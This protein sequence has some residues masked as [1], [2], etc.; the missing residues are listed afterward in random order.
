MWESKSGKVHGNQGRKGQVPWN[1]GK[2]LDMEKYPDYGMTGKQHTL[3]SRNQMVES[4]EGQISGVFQKG[5]EAWNKGQKGLQTHSQETRDLIRE[6]R[7]KQESPMKGKHHTQEAKDRLAIKNRE[8]TTKR[9][10]NPE[11][12]EFM[13]QMS[14][15][16]WQDPEYRKNQIELAKALWSDPVWAENTMARSLEVNQTIRPNKPEKRV[17]GLLDKVLPAIF[18]YVGD[19]SLW[20]KGKN[21]DF[22]NVNGKKQIIEVLGCYW[23]GCKKCFPKTEIQDDFPDRVQLYKSIGYST[24]GIWEH[25]LEF[26]EKVIERIQEFVEG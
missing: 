13:C 10:Q 26:P 7:I 4:H 14:K 6:A 17:I 15:E 2:S 3:E 9:W 25:E 24:L 1:K 23:H 8:D 18:E 22:V 21:P 5:H 16:L 12:R 11:Y 19:G 20:I